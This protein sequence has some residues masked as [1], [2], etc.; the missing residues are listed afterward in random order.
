VL[1][2]VPFLMSFPGGAVP[3]GGQLDLPFFAPGLGIPGLEGVQVAEQ[4]WLKAPGQPIVLSSQST[5][6]VL[7]ASL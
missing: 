4:S 5:L 6:I 1:V 7:S 2:D 3:P